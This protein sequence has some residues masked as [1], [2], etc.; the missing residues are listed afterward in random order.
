MLLNKPRAFAVMDRH[1]LDGLIATQRVNLYYLTDF[2]AYTMRVERLFNTFALLPRRE[3]AP[4]AMTINLTENGRLDTLGTWVPHVYAITGRVSPTSANV[5]QT[6]QELDT[7]ADPAG[8]YKMNPNAVLTP[9]EERWSAAA[10]KRV[11]FLAPTPIDALKKMVVEAGLTKG[12]I[13]TDDPRIIPWLHEMG[14][15][16]VTG[17]DATNIF[18]EIRMVKSPGE[19]KLLREA[20]RINEEAVEQVIKGLH[21]GSTQEE[22]ERDFMVEL[23]KRRGRGIF[24]LAGMNSGLRSGQIVKGEPF[25]IDA[26]GSYERY[27]GDLGRTCVFGEPDAELKKRNAAMQKGWQ[28]ACEAMKPGAKG[29]DI[30]KRVMKVVHQEGFPTFNHCIAHTLGVEHTD[31]PIPVGPNGMG[32][33]PDFVIEE[34]MVLNF[35]MPYQEWGWGSM[36]FEDT[37]LIN[38]GGFEP[39]TS[40][41]TELR[42]L[43]G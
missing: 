3:D 19:I 37:L 2:Y 24:I 13:G 43:Q 40:M 39:L 16:G 25:M 31:H 36:H 14:L 17:V 42:V 5:G 27:H 18:R 23:A 21:I 4:A 38:K 28:E 22:I 41:R 11:G 9:V 33:I 12:R 20:A 15:T 26:F 34:N 29:S 30:V 35:D 6:N 32:A 1:K 7:N 10:R 8:K